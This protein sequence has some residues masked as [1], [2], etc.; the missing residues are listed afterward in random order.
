M[1][2]P[3]HPL[4]LHYSNNTLRRVQIMKL[5]I[6]EGLEPITTVLAWSGSNLPALTRH[7][8]HILQRSLVEPPRIPFL[9]ER[10][11]LHW[12]GCTSRSLLIETNFN[13]LLFFRDGRCPS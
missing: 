12:V 1:L 10:K 11:L 4:R 6:P 8:R 13:M 7:T 2:R 5:F 9:R 3:S